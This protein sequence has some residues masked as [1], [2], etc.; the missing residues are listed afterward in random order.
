MGTISSV[1]ISE[2]LPMRVGR[3]SF[4]EKRRMIPHRKHLLTLFT[5]GKTL[6]LT[7]KI[8][9]LTVLSFFYLFINLSLLIDLIS[10]FMLEVR[11]ASKISLIECFKPTPLIIPDNLIINKEFIFPEARNLIFRQSC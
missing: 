3:L 4:I 1:K 7:Q 6:N 8:E 5:K 11:I 9:S 2:F 10:I